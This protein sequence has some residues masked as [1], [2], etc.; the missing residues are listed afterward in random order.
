[1]HTKLL[2]K[3]KMI[4]FLDHEINLVL[5]FIFFSV[6]ISHKLAL[7]ADDLLLFL[8]EKNE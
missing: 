4:I 2:A 8:F 7:Y 6:F 1:M 3:L 5:V